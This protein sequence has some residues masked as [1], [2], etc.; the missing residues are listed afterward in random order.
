MSFAILVR[1]MPPHT[2]TFQ[3][4]LVS[5]ATQAVR[6]P[7][8]FRANFCNPPP[9]SVGIFFIA[10]APSYSPGLA[11]SH[12]KMRYAVSTIL[13][14]MKGLSTIGIQAFKITC[15]FRKTFKLE[16]LA[17]MG[18]FNGFALWI[19][20]SKP[21]FCCVFIVGFHSVLL[22]IFIEITPLA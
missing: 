20:E 10:R 13:L 4:Y 2:N 5:T 18:A 9:S 21:T 19:W 7:L 11:V 3:F 14:Y 22:F 16:L 1:A 15:C 17:A 6:V 12:Q 8:N